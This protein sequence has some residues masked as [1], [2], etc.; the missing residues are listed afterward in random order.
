MEGA[1][2]TRPSSKQEL[3]GEPLKT[4]ENA[5]GSSTKTEIET[6]ETATQRSINT[7]RKKAKNNQ[8]R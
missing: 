6:L 4:T 5:S 7:F 3:E 2:N 1:T 8:L